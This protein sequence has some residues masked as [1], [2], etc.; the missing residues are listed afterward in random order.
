[1]NLTLKSSYTP[2]DLLTA[3]IDYVPLTAE[4]RD[5]LHAHIGKELYHVAPDRTFSS[6]Y[7]PRRYCTECYQRIKDGTKE[8]GT[9]CQHG[10]VK[11]GNSRPLYRTYEQVRAKNDE[12]IRLTSAWVQSVIVVDIDITGYPGTLQPLHEDV[13][14][15][16]MDAVG[17]DMCPYVLGI[18]RASGKAQIIYLIETV[19]SAHGRPTPPS[20]R[21]LKGVSE[22]LNAYYG[23]DT[24]FTH[25]F[26]RNPFTD[27]AGYDWYRVL[28]D[29]P[30]GIYS[31]RELDESLE[32]AGY[33]RDVPEKPQNRYSFVSDLLATAIDAREARE[34]LKKLE[35]SLPALSPHDRKRLAD[36][37]PGRIDG[38]KIVWKDGKEGIEVARDET[39]FRHALWIARLR[40]DN[41]EKY[42]PEDIIFS[43]IYAY[44][45]A[46]NVDKSGRAS[47]MPKRSDLETLAER[48]R[49]YVLNPTQE[50]TE[51]KRYSTGEFTPKERK[52]L[53]TLGRRG[54]QTTNAKRWD[55]SR[56]EY[57]DYRADALKN[58]DDANEQRRLAGNANRGKIYQ[59][60]YEYLVKQ[61]SKPSYAQ[62]M[63]ATGLKRTA[64]VTHLKALREAGLI[65]E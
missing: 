36:A 49:Y 48:I 6:G 42:V 56:A 47:E 7:L 23:A 29:R 43:Y 30:T 21:L 40:H 39:A 64:V 17:R 61:G 34:N 15:S 32:E 51:Y 31:L 24:H 27:G 35:E 14:R 57:T 3:G 62:L 22:R 38:V 28:S 11:C 10:D 65:S 59:A 50:V 54:A 12:Y 1:M 52:A 33:P 4:D 8:R 25:G 9:A 37:E 41:N 18:N 13:R 26:S 55:E 46:L 53:A 44:E 5:Y 58:L 19:Y 2:A 60:Y 63:D 20:K 16:L 45:I